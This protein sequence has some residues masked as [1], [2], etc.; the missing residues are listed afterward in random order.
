MAVISAE[1]PAVWRVSGGFVVVSD[2]SLQTIVP[3]AV[4]ILFTSWQPLW[5]CGLWPALK[6]DL[7][8]LIERDLNA[9]LNNIHYSR[10]IWFN[11]ILLNS[12]LRLH[13][14]SRQACHSFVHASVLVRAK[15]FAYVF[16]RA[17]ASDSDATSMQKQQQNKSYT[18]A[19]LLHLTAQNS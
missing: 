4:C 5:D 19:D 13:C 3:M 16:T 1:R 15:R 2:C 14:F 9:Q 8:Q 18:S 11:E 17:N 10:S 6:L 12:P 7:L